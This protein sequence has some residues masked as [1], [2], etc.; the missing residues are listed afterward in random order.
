LRFTGRAGGFF[1][2]PR[3][4]GEQIKLRKRKRRGNRNEKD[5]HAVAEL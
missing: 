4:A 5:R 1:F 3:T 2:P